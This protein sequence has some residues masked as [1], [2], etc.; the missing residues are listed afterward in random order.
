MR[1]TLDWSQERLRRGR[2]NEVLEP[3]EREME[4]IDRFVE[5]QRK[6][7]RELGLTKKD[8]AWFV[9]HAFEC[10]ESWRPLTDEEDEGSASGG[11]QAS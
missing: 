3:T 2:W 5:G 11:L 6:L 8:W 1:P 10:W 9:S 7:V 4:Q